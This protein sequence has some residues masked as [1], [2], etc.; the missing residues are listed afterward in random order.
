[1]VAISL[2]ISMSYMCF[3]ISPFLLAALFVLFLNDISAESFRES[4]ASQI[5]R[6][7]PLFIQSHPLPFFPFSSLYKCVNVHALLKKKHNK[8]HHKTQKQPNNI[9]PRK[10]P[11]VFK[12]DLF[13]SCFWPYFLCVSST[14]F[15]KI[16][17]M[18]SVWQS[19]VFCPFP[20][21]NFSVGRTLTT[22]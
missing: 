3:G 22:G 12:R 5:Q 8:N 10:R 11:L 15:Y 16:R 20:C 19:L 13:F 4:C 21:Q 14:N 18:D 7:R 2:L 1:M 9:L 6:N 17:P